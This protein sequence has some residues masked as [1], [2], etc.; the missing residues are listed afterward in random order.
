MKHFALLAIS[1]FLLLAG[2]V[3]AQ[4]NFH[5]DEF[6]TR[7]KQIEEFIDRFSY[8]DESKRRGYQLLSRKSN[9]QN[10]DITDIYRLIYGGENTSRMSVILSLFNYENIHA[11]GKNSIKDFV[12]QVTD[13]TEGQ[14]LNFYDRDWYAAVEV[15][16]TYQNR[17]EDGILILQNC[18]DKDEEGKPGSYWGLVSAS[19]NF[20]RKGIDSKERKGVNAGAHGV[21][22]VPLISAFKNRESSFNMVSDNFVSNDL[23]ILLYA[24]YNGDVSIKNIKKI[25]YHFMQIDGWVFRV[26]YHNRSTSNSGWLISDLIKADRDEKK[27]YREQVLRVY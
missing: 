11:I 5:S 7:I 16:F 27:A 24:N 12:K 17:T 9:S 8:T 14:T 15:E 10:R 19:A 3:E 4:T 21:N 22:F 18:I 23:D 13:P 6:I 2:S 26:D 25:S 1:L 20:L